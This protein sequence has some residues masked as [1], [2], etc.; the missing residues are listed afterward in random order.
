MHPGAVLTETTRKMIEDQPAAASA[1]RWKTV[2]Q[3]AATSVWAG[4]V[5]ADEVGGHYCEDC[6]VAIV[7]D[8]PAEAFGVRAF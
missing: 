1:F 7:N 8:R 5:A 4:F 2:Q 6:H 3:G